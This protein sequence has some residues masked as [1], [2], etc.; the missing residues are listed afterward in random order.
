[1]GYAALITCLQQIESASTVYRYRAPSLE[2]HGA[3]KQSLNEGYLVIE[4]Q[5][6]DDPI[7]NEVRPYILAACQSIIHALD[8]GVMELTPEAPSRFMAREFCAE[9]SRLV[10]RLMP[11]LQAM[12]AE[13]SRAECG[14]KME[15]GNAG[16]A[17][18]AV[19]PLR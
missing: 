17:H 12:E 8:F 16:G 6:R 7:I 9:L 11:Y 4:T 15:V 14:P 2:T 1:M 13:R 3:L 10:R 19:E 18:P 5:E